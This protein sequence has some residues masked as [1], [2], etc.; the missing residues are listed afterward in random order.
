[1][2]FVRVVRWDKAAEMP[3]FLQ[4]VLPDIPL[5][6]VVWGKPTSASFICSVNLPYLTSK[7]LTVTWPFGR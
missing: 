1:M 5:V 4:R 7:A 3:M 6:L 2:S